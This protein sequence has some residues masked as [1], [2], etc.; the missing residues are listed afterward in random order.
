LRESQLIKTNAYLLFAILPF[1]II[2]YLFAIYEESLFFLYEWSLTLLISASIVLSIFSIIKIKSNL[3][4]ISTSILAFLVQLSVLCI[5]LGPV[6]SRLLF[7]LFYIISFLSIF[8][9]V[10]ALRKIDKFKFLP[11]TFI[12]LSVILTLYM[13]FLNSL[14]G[15]D[16]TLGFFH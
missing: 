3:K 16:L 13:V 8:I 12:F 2:G 9:F 4:W 7:P 15:E 5:F 1:S 14:W 10:A 6:T 11:V